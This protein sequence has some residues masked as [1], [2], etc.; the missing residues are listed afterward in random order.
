MHAFAQLFVLLVRP[1]GLF[2][3]RPHPFGVA[4]RAGN[5]HRRCAA[6][7]SNRLF[8][9]RRFEVATMIL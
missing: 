9:C 3:L 6:L 2:G 7:S 8:V 1:D 4:G 5:R